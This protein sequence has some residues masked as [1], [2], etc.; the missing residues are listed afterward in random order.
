VKIHFELAELRVPLSAVF[1]YGF[2]EDMAG[3]KRECLTTHAVLA[4]KLHL[5]SC[6]QIGNL[7]R[8]LRQLRLVEWK[9]QGDSN[10]YRVLGP[11]LEWI[12][13]LMRQLRP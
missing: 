11:D 12:A 13:E 5:R 8:L 4:Q 6:R 3:R 9:R 7:L 1:L 2:L 10:R